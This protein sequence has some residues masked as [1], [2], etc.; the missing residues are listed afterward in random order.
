MRTA[1]RVLIKDYRNHTRVLIPTISVGTGK[2]RIP[3]ITGSGVEELQIELKHANR[4]AFADGNNTESVRIIITPPEGDEEFRE[5]YLR[6]WTDY[7]DAAVDGTSVRMSPTNT[8]NWNNCT[9]TLAGNIHLDI[10]NIDVEG[11]IASIS[12]LE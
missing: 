11:R 12:Q 3:R 1:P 7:F 5:N 9:I 6:E 8:T 10:R 2:H 4:T